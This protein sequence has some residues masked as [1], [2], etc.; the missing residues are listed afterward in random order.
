MKTNIFFL[1][2]LISLIFFTG[3]TNYDPWLS[4]GITK[5]EADL[6]MELKFT[7]KKANL[8][9]KNGFSPS[10]SF[11]WQSRG[12]VPFKGNKLGSNRSLSAVDWKKSGFNLNDSI[13]CGEIQVL[14]HLKPKNG[15]IQVL[16]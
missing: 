16:N 11:K 6:W 13:A 7:V 12:F 2:L 9:N 14:I 10:E 3:C 8:W 1:S 15:E 5:Q 4:S